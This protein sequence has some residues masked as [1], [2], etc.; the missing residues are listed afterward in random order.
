MYIDTSDETEILT[1]RKHRVAR[2]IPR[3]MENTS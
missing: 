2:F 3:C 1:T